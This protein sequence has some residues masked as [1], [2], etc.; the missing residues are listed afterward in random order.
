MK[1]IIRG[2]KMWVLA[3]MDGY[4]SKFDVYQGKA[5]AHQ[6]LIMIKMMVSMGL[7]NKLSKL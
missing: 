7:V 2:Y 6:L 1:P 5:G 4:N 3:D